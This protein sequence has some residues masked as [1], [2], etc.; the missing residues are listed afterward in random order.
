MAAVTQTA[1]QKAGGS[2]VMVKVTGA[3][4]DAYFKDMGGY[5]LGAGTGS[6][7]G[8]FLYAS[9]TDLAMTNNVYNGVPAGSLWLDV[10]TGQ[11]YFNDAGTSL[12]SNTWT[13]ISTAA[14]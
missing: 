2:F 4:A 6:P 7:D 8:E 13:A 9:P 3:T 5:F 14:S 12:T 10:A 11:W 1:R